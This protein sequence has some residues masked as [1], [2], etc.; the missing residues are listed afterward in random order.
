MLDDQG[1]EMDEQ[2]KLAEIKEMR[3]RLIGEMVGLVEVE[4]ST[5]M[6]KN[7]NRGLIDFQKFLTA[8]SKSRM[9]AHKRN[10]PM[11]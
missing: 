1:E 5:K 10:R 11:R 8:M 7:P 6:K 2:A 4:R 9:P 3:K